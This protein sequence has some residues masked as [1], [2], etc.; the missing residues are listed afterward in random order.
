MEVINVKRT[1]IILV[2]IM[3][4]SILSGCSKPLDGTNEV[5]N[6]EK[7][8]EN[9]NILIDAA[10]IEC[11][12]FEPINGEVKTFEFS[13]K[14]GFLEDVLNDWINELSKMKISYGSTANRENILDELLVVDAYLDID[15]LI[16]VM[17]DNFKAFESSDS[18][19]YTNPGNFLFGLKDILSK[20]TDVASLTINYHGKKSDIIGSEGLLI[21][22][23]T[24]RN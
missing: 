1:S 20:V 2:V 10:E 3:I 11:N 5:I 21:D 24:L 19:N 7:N 8:L 13:V 18:T 12:Y 17:N 15:T 16:I 6:S 22:N 4:V 23:I 9:Q 14:N